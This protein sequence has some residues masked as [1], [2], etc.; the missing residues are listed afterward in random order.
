MSTINIKYLASLAEKLG[1][2]SDSIDTTDCDIQS[3][4]DSLNP[5]VAMPANTVCAINF[6]YATLD[7]VVKTGDELAFFPPVTGG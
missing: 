7:T 6:Q 2:S 3:I 5:T 1:K 4:W